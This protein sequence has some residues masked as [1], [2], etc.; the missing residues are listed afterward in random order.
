MVAKHNSICRYLFSYCEYGRHLY[1]YRNRHGR[2]GILLTWR[3]CPLHIKRDCIHEYRQVLP[4][5]ASKGLHHATLL[6]GIEPG[7]EVSQGAVNTEV[8]FNTLH[9][10]A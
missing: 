9:F 8:G 2:E 1:E 10:P 3:S 5:F 4:D 6:P 7:Q